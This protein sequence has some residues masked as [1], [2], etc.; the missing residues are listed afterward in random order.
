MGYDDKQIILPV[1]VWWTWWWSTTQSR[2]R[3][4]TPSRD[5]NLPQLCLCSCLRSQQQQQRYQQQRQLGC[6]VT[7]PAACATC[8]AAV[9]RPSR[10][11]EAPVEY[12]D[13]HPATA[14]SDG[15]YDQGTLSNDG[16]NGFTQQC[17]TWIWRIAK[18]FSLLMHILWWFQWFNPQVYKRW[19]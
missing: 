19:V 7:A 9:H 10:E 11:S 2:N 5:S 8:S 3:L 13:I 6:V 12:L 18:W 1:V 4:T 14:C 17:L 15:S 16:L